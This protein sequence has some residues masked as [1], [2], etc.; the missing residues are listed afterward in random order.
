MEPKIGASLNFGREDIELEL[1]K[2][3]F[4]QLLPL[5]KKKMNDKIIFIK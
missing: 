5:N 1:F 4:K 2:P 3:I